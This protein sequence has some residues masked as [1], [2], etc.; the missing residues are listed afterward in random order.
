[1]RNI[2]KTD[3]LTI[4]D[5]P[6]D[7]ASWNEIVSFALTF[8]PML[9]LGT[10]DIYK[11]QFIEFDERSSLQELRRSAFLWQRAWNHVSKEIDEK[12]LET[13]KHLFTLMRKKLADS[14]VG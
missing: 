8:D 4:D 1:M 13:F 10:T 14:R 11:P 3:E 9:E 6:S 12:G 5:I 2:I 7:S